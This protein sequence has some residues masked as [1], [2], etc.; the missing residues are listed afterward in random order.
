MEMKAFAVA[1][2][3]QMKEPAV[4]VRARHGGVHKDENVER[5]KVF[6]AIKQL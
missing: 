3:A 5:R 4:C 1:Y 6:S 2:G